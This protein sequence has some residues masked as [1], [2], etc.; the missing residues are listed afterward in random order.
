MFRLTLAI[1]TGLT[2]GIPH[3]FGEDLKISLARVPG[4]TYVSDP[5]ALD[6]PLPNLL[7]LVD[8]YY[9]DGSFDMQSY[10]F[11]R[12]ISNVI[13]KRADVHAPLIRVAGDQPLEFRYV[14][15]ALLTVTFVIYSKKDTPL[16]ADSDFS[17]YRVDTWI[18]H[19]EFFDF[20]VNEVTSIQSGLDRV[21]NGRSDALIMGQDPVDKLLRSTGKYDNIHRAH[22][23]NLD[24]ALR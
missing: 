8:K 5:T 12:S 4:L 10:P 7:S 13:E 18:G 20:E 11:N 19:A 21:S 1:L 15:E 16:T 22:Y 9:E 17:R 23:A 24:S 6:G 14:D 3:S 2:L